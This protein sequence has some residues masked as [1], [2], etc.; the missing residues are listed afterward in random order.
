MWVLYV[1]DSSLKRIQKNGSAFLYISVCSVCKCKCRFPYYK[2][3]LRGWAWVSLSIH[4]TKPFLISRDLREPSEMKVDQALHTLTPFSESH[5]QLESSHTHNQPTN[6]LT[7][8]LYRL[9]VSCVCVCVLL[10]CIH[11]MLRL[12]VSMNSAF[13]L[14]KTTKLLMSNLQTQMR[15]REKV[16]LLSYFLFTSPFPLSFPT[17]P[18]SLVL[19]SSNIILIQQFVAD[20]I[21][22]HVY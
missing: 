13:S 14:R 21:Y 2:S 20:D 11:L 16:R 3:T 8:T 6:Q 15:E 7:I 10:C 4:F 1:L 5:R 18:H 22:L 12:P 17:T 19:L 9:R